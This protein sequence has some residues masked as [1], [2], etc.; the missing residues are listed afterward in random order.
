MR[1]KKEIAV[2]KAGD[3]SLN[4]EDPYYET[5]PEELFAE[6]INAIQCTKEGHYVNLVT[7][8]A[9]GDP[10]DWLIPRLSDLARQNN[11]PV[12]EIRYIDQCGCGGYVTRVFIGQHSS[13]K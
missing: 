13:G 2:M 4:L 7:P 1:M 8:G 5:N 6:S 10:R 9:C 12:R 11:L 3:W